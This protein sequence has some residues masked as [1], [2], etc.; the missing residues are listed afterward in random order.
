ML[1]SA[2]CYI[3]ILGNFN[4]CPDSNKYLLSGPKNVKEC[5]GRLIESIR[6]IAYTENM[7]YKFSHCDT[8]S[9]CFN[10]ILLVLKPSNFNAQQPL[11]DSPIDS[12]KENLFYVSNPSF[13]IEGY[14]P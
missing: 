4:K 8:E 12:L 6:T 1:V 9:H 3:R 5:P 7:E 2:H 11:G 14:Y 13:N 10:I